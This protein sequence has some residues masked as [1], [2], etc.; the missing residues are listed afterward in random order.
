MAEPVALVSWA[1]K[2]IGDAKGTLERTERVTQVAQKLGGAVDL[3][4]WPMGQHDIA[5]VVDLPSDEASS[6]LA[7]Q[8]G[9]LVMVRTETL[10]AFTAKEMGQILE[11][12]A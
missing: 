11:H 6:T 2:G 12:L 4:L 7:L 1:K 3:L 9:A 5:G 8:I 10:R